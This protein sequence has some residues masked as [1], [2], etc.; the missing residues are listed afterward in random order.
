MKRRLFLRIDQAGVASTD[1]ERI[2]RC[3]AIDQLDAE[4]GL[5]RLSF[6]PRLLDHAELLLGERPQRF[7]TDLSLYLNTARLFLRRTPD[8]VYLSLPIDSTPDHKR[9][10][11]EDMGV[12]IGSI[13]MVM[14]LG[15]RWE[16]IAQIPSNARVSRLT[17]DFVGF[18]DDNAKRVYEAKGTT[19]A[20]T[21]ASHHEKAKKQLD[22]CKEPNVG[23]YAVVTYLAS[24]KLTPP[25][26]VFVSDPGVPLPT[27]NRGMA[28][29]LHFRKIME[30]CG[31]EE[32]AIAFSKC[33]S[34]RFAFERQ[35]EAGN[36]SY[37]QWD[38][39][40]DARRDAIRIADALRS[41]STTTRFH[42]SDFIG[43]RLTTSVLGTLLTLFMGVEREYLYDNVDK[44]TD[45]NANVPFAPRSFNSESQ[46]SGETR[47]SFSL[48]S[49]GSLLLIEGLNNLISPMRE[50][51]AQA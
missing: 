44:L 35:L 31:F 47:E 48:L 39:L 30:F 40:M 11:A 33:I 42:D 23:K 16:T 19:V 45:T 3:P 32:L 8:D 2:L 22:S 26:T 14:A 10:L 17:P 1:L 50:K 18:D 41:S 20:E 38:S 34:L 9:K 6:S 7:T 24:S 5:Y 4:Q 51:E 12:A 28:T 13:F 49:D 27:V 25:S 46:P 37:R 21:V 36:D 15:L 43:R 29:A